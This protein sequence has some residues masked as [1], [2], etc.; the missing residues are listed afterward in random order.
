MILIDAN[1]LIYAHSASFPQHEPART[2]LDGRL[3]DGRKVGL[4]WE[5]LLA[6][7]RVLSNP[8]IVEQP[9]TPHALWIQVQRWLEVE[10]VWIPSL[11]ED[12]AT[13]LEALMPYVVRS[14]LVP[15][16]HLAAIAMSHG[17]TLCSTDGDFARFESLN[18]TNPLQAE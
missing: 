4:P 10:S 16:A 15:D 7:Q 13:I 14:A 12:H 6:F 1:L 18:W 8:R 3:N 9:E 2:W 5:S 17:L 11:T